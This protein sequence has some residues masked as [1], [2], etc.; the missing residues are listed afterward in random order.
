MM[1][2][3]IFA[4]FAIWSFVA[5]YPIIPRINIP[6]FQQFL[7]DNPFRS[8]SSTRPSLRD[9]YIMRV[10]DY[11]HNLH[12]NP[13]QYRKSNFRLFANQCSENERCRDYIENI[14]ALQSTDIIF[15]DYLKL[16]LVQFENEYNEHLTD[17]RRFLRDLYQGKQDYEGSDETFF[18][19][20][21]ITKRTDGQDRLILAR[22]ED[23]QMNGFHL[24]WDH[25]LCYITKERL[26]Q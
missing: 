9:I 15:G 24:L 11:Y 17:D 19:I 10:A 16:R 13:Y 3:P 4:I 14:V 2:I 23:Y 6:T 21:N 18:E 8:Y 7:N 22:V 12:P 26:T 25:Y 20:W 1:R 5:S